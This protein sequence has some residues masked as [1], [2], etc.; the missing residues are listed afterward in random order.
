MPKGRKE[1]VAT[2]AFILACRVE[3]VDMSSF[4]ISEILES[5]GHLPKILFA[6]TS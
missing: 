6:S 2:Y 3:L 5:I 1:K 4:K